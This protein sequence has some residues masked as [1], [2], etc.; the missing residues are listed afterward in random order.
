MPLITLMKK[1]LEWKAEILFLAFTRI[2][3]I[4]SSTHAVRFKPAGWS[5]TE[6]IKVRRP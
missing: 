6:M 1:L 2:V 3:H 5:V 4:N